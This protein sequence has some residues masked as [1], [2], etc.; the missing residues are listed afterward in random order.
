MLCVEDILQRQECAAA[1]FPFEPSW[2]MMA[3]REGANQG[4]E[5]ARGAHNEH[6]ASVSAW[7]D[8]SLDAI[9]ALAGLAAPRCADCGVRGLGESA[10]QE[11][12]QSYDPEAS[13][14]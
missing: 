10:A 7:N 2:L 3:G 9:H 1:G 8:G 12:A 5:I 11:P 4:K 14:E 13:S 6:R